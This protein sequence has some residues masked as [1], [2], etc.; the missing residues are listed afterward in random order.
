[1]KSLY[2]RIAVCLLLAIVVAAMYY[3]MY[4]KSVSDYQRTVRDMQIAEVDTSQLTDG[5]YIGDCNV[6]FIYAKVAVQIQNGEITQIQILEHRNE[7]GK[8]A[9]S[10][11][12]EIV[13]EQKINVDA[14][15]GATNSSTV[16]K[17]A[18]ETALSK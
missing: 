18:V 9:E 7:R 6:N 15:S 4:L 13:K 8:Q 12:D 14:V 16:L 2:H 3:G 10:V 1:M 17:K 11:L 5:T